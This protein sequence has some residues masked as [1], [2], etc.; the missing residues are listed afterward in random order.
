MFGWGTGSNPTQD[1]TNNNEYESFVDWGNNNILNGG[2]R[3]WR[4]LTKD[5]WTY[6]FDERNTPSGIRFCPAQGVPRLTFVFLFSCKMF[7]YEPNCLQMVY[8][9]EL[10]SE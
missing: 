6:V 4:T 1:A 10:P 9:S 8:Q 5:E 3:S 7:N 2:G